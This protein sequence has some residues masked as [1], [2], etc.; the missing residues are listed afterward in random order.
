MYA[1]ESLNLS[2]FYTLSTT[3]YLN[4][5]TS[6][7]LRAYTHVYE[8]RLTGKHAALNFVYVIYTLAEFILEG[9]VLSKTGNSCDGFKSKLKFM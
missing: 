4:K 2:K 9:G 6:K 1:R 7:I 3:N 8:K 5:F